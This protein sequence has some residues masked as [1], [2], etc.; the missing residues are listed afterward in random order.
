MMP[1]PSAL[2]ASPSS[3]WEPSHSQ[4]SLFYDYHAA[5]I[6][7][8][9]NVRQTVQ[10]KVRLSF[11]TPPGTTAEDYDRR[12]GG[13]SERQYSAEIRVS[14]DEHSIFAT[15]KLEDFLIGRCLRSAFSDMKRLVTRFAEFIGHSGRG[16]YLKGISRSREKRNL[17]FPYR[18]SSVA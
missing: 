11:G 13:P 1:S 6:Q 3:D 17:S 8:F 4:A 10:K 5:Q 18:R 7:G 16:R 12:S 9:P 2:S 15:C 14:R